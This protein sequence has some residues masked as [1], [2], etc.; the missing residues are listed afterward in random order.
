MKKKFLFLFALLF[1]VFCFPQTTL[2]DIT[3]ESQDKALHDSTGNVAL[4]IDFI[5]FS[6]ESFISE[7]YQIPSYNL[8]GQLWDTEHVRSKQ[9]TI[10]FSDNMLKIILVESYNTPF[11]FP[12]RGKMIAP[13]GSVKKGGFHPGI[14]FQ[15]PSNEPVYACF[16]GVVR[17]AKIYGDYGKMVVIRHYNGLETVYAH[18]N[19]IYVKPGQIVKAGHTIGVSGTSA[20]SKTQILHFET[21]FLNEFFNPQLLFD[22]E[23]RTLL[24]NILT[25]EPSHFNIKTIPS[26]TFIDN[27]ESAEPE[28]VSPV[29]PPE[30]S[31]TPGN[32]MYHVVQKGET[33]F[34]ISRKYNLSVQE[35]LSI[36][37]LSEKSTIYAGQRLRVK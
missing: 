17:V 30:K 27:D 23:E 26:K 15:L 2:L 29:L 32:P 18:L 13:F 28:T 20:I 9:F 11:V 7:T 14:D 37:K 19:N 25:L 5:D 16:D 6:Q 22:T 34:G 1:P 10:P 33:L 4:Q 36:N 35:L 31:T 12:C 21:R 8:Y 3:D 24:G